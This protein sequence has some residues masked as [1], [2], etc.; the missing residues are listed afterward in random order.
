MDGRFTYTYT[1]MKAA[2]SIL[3]LTVELIEKNYL[4]KGLDINAENKK[5]C[6]L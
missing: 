4:E 1:E 2:W 6:Y 3:P 5:S